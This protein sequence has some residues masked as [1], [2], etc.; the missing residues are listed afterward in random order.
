MTELEMKLKAKIPGVDTGIEIRHSLCAICSP[1]HHCGLDCYVKDGEIIRVEG[2]AEHPYSHGRLCTKGSAQRSYIYRED[3]IRT[4][5]RRVGERGGGKFE[6]ISWDEAYRIIAERLNQVKKEYSPHSVAFYSGYSKWYRPIYHRFAHVFGSVNFGTDDSVCAVSKKMA[7]KVTAGEDASSDMARANTFLGWNYD[8]YYSHHLSVEGVRKLKERGGKVIII[9]I[10]YTPAA[11]NLADI[12]L[13]INPGTDGA[14]ALGMAKLIID[15]GWADMEYVDKYTY[16]FEQYRELV[17]E[18][19]LEKVSEITGLKPDDIY[20][21]TKLFATNGPACTN[22]SA[23]ALVHHINGFNTHRAIVCL[24]ALTGNFD[25]P[26]GNYPIPASFLRQSAGFKS[27]D[28]EFRT[29]REPVGTARIGAQRFP[30][31]DAQFNE[32]QAMDLM[33]QM[34]EETPYPVKA[35]F[36]LGLNAKMFPETD[37]L[38]EVMKQKLDFIV[39]VDLFMTMSAK[40]ADIV[41][42]ACTSVER[43]ELKCYAGGYLVYTRPAIEPLYES[44]S[45]VNILCELARA[46]DLDDDLLKGGYEA[47]CDWMIQGCGLTIADLKKSDM[48]VK[49]PTTVWPV[50][51]GNCLKNGFKTSTGKFEFYSTAIAAIDPAFGL[52]PLP[53]YRDSLE[54]QNSAEIREKY[55]FYLCTG[56]RMPYAIHSRVHRTPWLRSLRPKPTCEINRQ[57]AARMGLGNG[58]SVTLSSPHGEIHMQVKVTS[59]IKPGVILALPGYSEA[60]VNNLIGRNH[61]DPYSGFPGYKGMRCNMSKYQEAES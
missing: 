16:G 33:R 7:D 55:P 53:S 8:G 56:A 4:P 43:S 29:N 44:K 54:D 25:R 41:L 15:N 50:E 57:D 21:A 49:V 22:Y 11:K 13:H 1:S 40:Y 3:R 38:L 31:W 34:E 17:Q 52:D 47:C 60:N 39:D 35:V 9:D 45:D 58:S 37:R 2:T 14:L 30:L 51:P 24:A 36:A 32:F 26:G 61:L 10:R 42:P 20:E 46:M 27:R 23:S 59:K 28:E 5:L 48:P 18:Y 12:F 6:P 19:S